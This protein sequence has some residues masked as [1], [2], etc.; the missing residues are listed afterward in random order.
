MLPVGPRDPELRPRTGQRQLTQFGAPPAGGV[1]GVGPAANAGGG[2][3]FGIG[4]LAMV[5]AA[6]TVYVSVYLPAAP[7][8][9]KD[10]AS[11]FNAFSGNFR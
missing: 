8:N 2:G 1:H 3:A 4:G 5:L 7:P 9:F 6:Q 10:M 11:Q